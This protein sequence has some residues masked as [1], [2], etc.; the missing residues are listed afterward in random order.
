MKGRGKKFFLLSLLL[1][2]DEAH[3]HWRAICFPPSADPNAD[4]IRN[5]LRD[6]SRNTV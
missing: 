1:Y 3:A 5:T 6:T 2:S 4:L